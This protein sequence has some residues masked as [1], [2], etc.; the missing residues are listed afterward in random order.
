MN[1]A[2]TKVAVANIVVKAL[3]RPFCHRTDKVTIC[4]PT[5]WETLINANLVRAGVA[6]NVPSNYYPPN[7]PEN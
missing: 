4:I 2:E 1:V 6:R 5:P 3:C 7:F